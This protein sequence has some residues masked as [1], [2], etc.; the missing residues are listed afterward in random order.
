MSNMKVTAICFKCYCEN[1]NTPDQ[2]I[3]WTIEVVCK[4]STGHVPL[5]I[6]MQYSHF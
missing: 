2:M 1:T 4:H 6:S 3:N 5:F